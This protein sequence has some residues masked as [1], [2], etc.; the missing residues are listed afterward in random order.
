MHQ[1]PQTVIACR[2][3]GGATIFYTNVDV[4]KV[5][6]SK[7]CARLFSATLLEAV[8]VEHGYRNCCIGKY[9]DGGG[10]SDG[11]KDTWGASP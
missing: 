2:R 7:N 6:S 9:N 10:E 5:S 4:L 8:Y 1:I 3:T 11:A